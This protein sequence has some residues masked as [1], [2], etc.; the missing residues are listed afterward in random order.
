M[1]GDSRQGENLPLEP[2]SQPDPALPTEPETRPDPNL[3][4]DPEWEGAWGEEDDEEE[5]TN[6]LTLI[7]IGVIVVIL[8]AFLVWLYLPVISVWVGTARTPTPS[9]APPT[10]TLR[11]T[12]TPTITPSPTIP[13]T[14]TVTPYAPSAYSIDSQELQPPLP[15]YPSS[16]IVL[17]DDRAVTPEPDYINPAWSP[18]S[19]IST[20]LPAIVISEPYHTTFANGSAV[21]KMDAPLKP[22]MYEIY[23]SDTTYSSSDALEFHVNVGE[24]ALLP[25]TSR[26]RVE[27]WTTSG[28]PPQVD[29]LWHSIGIY[30]I[31]QD[32][33]LSVST[34]W[35][36]RDE[37]SGPV[38]IDRVLIVP[39][40]ENNV[41]LISRIPADRIK[42]VVDDTQAKITGADFLLDVTDQ[43]AWND[44]YQKIVNTTRDIKVIW[45]LQDSVAIGTYEVAV[46]VPEIM[47]NAVVTYRLLANGVELPRSDDS[48]LVTSSQGNWP[49]GQWVM[50]GGWEIPRI[51]E[52]RVRLSLQMDI[53]ANTPGEAAIDAAIFMTIPTPV[54]EP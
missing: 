26:Q 46:F 23:V 16:V 49:G 43:V 52:P 17:D 10:A 53:L 14:A 7:I 42:Y 8:L 5:K 47:G 27:Y 28:T 37:F 48:V 51:Y 1:T 24:Q 12:R 54:T 45:E 9:A 21:W 31:E 34:F 19:A 41:D 25:I 38:A 4:L 32:G 33:L 18:S 44:T 29:D 13:P 15:W 6:P 40:S 2:T 3:E 39:Q 22:G 20:Q 50:L 11:P 36:T 30:R 35:D